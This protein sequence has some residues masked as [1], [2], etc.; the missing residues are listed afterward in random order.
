MAERRSREICPPPFQ[1]DGN[2]GGTAAFTEMLLQ[3]HDGR[4]VLLPALPAAADWQ[5]G[6]F[7]GIAARGGYT[8]DCKW[9]NGEVVKY[10]LRR[11]GETAADRVIVEADGVVRTHDM[12][13]KTVMQCELM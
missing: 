1:I 8:V 4:I 9:Q 6:E 2:F 3:S 13:G 12:T 7:T 10:V 5:N 11:T